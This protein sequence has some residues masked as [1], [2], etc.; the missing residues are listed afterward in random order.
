MN[1]QPK[2]KKLRGWRKILELMIQKADNPEKWFDEWGQTKYTY[3]PKEL[4]CDCGKNKID[5]LFY[6]T[7]Q[8]NGNVLRS[9]SCCVKNLR[10]E[11][12]E[13]CKNSLFSKSVDKIIKKKKNKKLKEDLKK[14]I[15]NNETFMFRVNSS[16]IYPDKFDKFNNGINNIQLRGVHSINKKDL[17]KKVLKNAPF[18]DSKA[19]KSYIKVT[20][21]NINLEDYLKKTKDKIYIN[22]WIKKG[23]SHPVFFLKEFVEEFK[24]QNQLIL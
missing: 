18:W 9:G 15:R 5:E 1:E 7:N 8:I 16:K 13:K 22:C 14:S 17:F 3:I 23:S 10:D 20:C 12:K 11:L 21:K 24:P 4:K 2:E 6:W 19:N